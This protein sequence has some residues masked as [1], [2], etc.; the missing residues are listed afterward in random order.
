MKFINVA[1]NI[2]VKTTTIA[3][4]F[5]HCKICS[6]QGMASEPQV[7]KDECIDGLHEAI[8]GLHYRNVIDIDHL[9][10]YPNE[11]DIVIESPIYEEIIQGVMNTPIDDHDPDDINVLPNV[12]SKESFK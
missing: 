9:L 11:N 6:D 8:S 2:D 12:S 10:N 1:W 5:R 4:C 3:H 7:G